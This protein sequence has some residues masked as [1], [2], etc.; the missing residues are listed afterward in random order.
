MKRGVPDDSV[1][2]LAWQFR[3][4]VDRYGE[5]PI[6][7][8]V[9]TEYLTVYLDQGLT[10]LKIGQGGR[11]PLPTSLCPEGWLSQKCLPT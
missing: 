3:E 4:L 8:E 11:V 1:N 6:F 7:S 9:G 5:R 2:D 10:L